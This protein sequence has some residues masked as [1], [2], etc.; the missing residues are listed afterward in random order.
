[1]LFRDRVEVALRQLRAT[2]GTL[3]LL[4]LDLDHFKNVNDTLG[5]P[6]GDALLELVSRRLL[7]CV[8]ETDV[9]GRLGGDEFAVLHVAEGR[10]PE[11]EALARRIIDALGAPYVVEGRRVVVGA[12]VGLA[13]AAGGDAGAGPDVLLK[14]ADMALYRAKAEG[15]GTFRVFEAEMDAAVQARL[16]IESDLREAV[17]RR[18]FELYYQPLFDLRARRVSGYEA[19]IRWRHPE[20]GLIPP[21]QFVPIAEEMGLIVPIGEWV[22]HRACADAA[23]WPAPVKVAVNLSPVHFRAG[24][25]VGAVAGA[26]RR[27]GLDPSRLELEITESALLRDSDAVVATLHRVRGLGPRIAMDDFGT[28]YS[29][30]SYLRSFPFDKIKIDQS[31]VREM[32]GRPDC[33]A[34]VNSVSDLAARL[35]MTTTAEGVETAEQLGMV[36]RAGCTEA[37][38][39]H[40]GGPLPLPEVAR[41]LADAERASTRAA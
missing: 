28:G 33:F 19:L 36:R 34:I 35:G 41:G 22:A 27:S 18:Q 30:L 32:G 7:G 13:F 15:R 9:V 40:F 21:A 4:C 23:A 11:A 38:G 14:N 5:H 26:L 31:F 2:S 10:P 6:A 8:R 25:V 37:Q 39:Y 16:A 12:S 1:V 24:D 29:S 3:A 17:E 20:R